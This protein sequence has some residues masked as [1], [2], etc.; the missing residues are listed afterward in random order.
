MECPTNPCFSSGVR[1]LCCVPLAFFFAIGVARAQTMVTAPNPTGPDATL[2]ASPITSSVKY[3]YDAAGR[4]IKVQ[5]G[6]RTVITYIYDPA[7]NLLSR[8]VSAGGV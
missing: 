1:T 8:D 6:T 7:G 4:L 3:T 2:A 5:Y